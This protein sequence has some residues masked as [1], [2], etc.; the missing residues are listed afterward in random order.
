MKGH[1]NPQDLTWQFRRIVLS[2]GLITERQGKFYRKDGSEFAMNDMKQILEL[3]EKEHLGNETIT[4]TGT[5]RRA[6]ISAYLK[7]LQDLSGARAS[8]VRRAVLDYAKNHGYRLDAS[9]IKFGGLGGSE[10]IVTFPAEGNIEAGRI[11]RRVEVR[12]IQVGVEDIHPEEF[13]R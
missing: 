11:N 2:R 1:A 7:E 3:I 4:E 8:S 10:P 9:Q 6:T 13:A 12:I 5:A